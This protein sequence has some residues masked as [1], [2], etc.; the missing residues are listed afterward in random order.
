ME[1]SKGFALDDMPGV[2]DAVGPISSERGTR[3]V[4]GALGHVKRGKICFF[5]HEC[6]VL[7]I[8]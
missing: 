5:G 6:V 8:K 7:V 4:N 3:F 1:E 2:R